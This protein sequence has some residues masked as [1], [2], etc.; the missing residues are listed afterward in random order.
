MKRLV[1]NI[2]VLSTALLTSCGESENK[3][4]ETVSKVKSET[5]KVWEEFTIEALGNT[6]DGHEI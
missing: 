3:V 6:N 2:L 4:V 1:I 5:E